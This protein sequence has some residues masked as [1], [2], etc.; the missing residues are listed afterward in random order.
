MAFKMLTSGA[1]TLKA[2]PRLAAAAPA[3]PTPRAG[4]ISTT[5][6][7]R[8]EKSLASTEL[9]M[10]SSSQWAQRS[11]VFPQSDR[12]LAQS[13]FFRTSASLGVS[14]SRS[15]PCSSAAR[16]AESPAIS[17]ST[18]GRSDFSRRHV[19]RAPSGMVSSVRSLSRRASSRPA[20][21]TAGM[22][23]RS[24][25]GEGRLD[26]TS[27]VARRDRLSTSR[28]CRCTA[29]R[30]PTICARSPLPC[31]LTAS[32]LNVS[33]RTPSPTARVAGAPLVGGDAAAASQGCSSPMR[34]DAAGARASAA[35][36]RR[37]WAR[38]CVR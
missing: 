18:H 35:Q 10:S 20:R 25:C 12:Q 37:A 7:R 2:S 17:A 23:S 3:S 34:P 11:P 22:T 13:P 14:G 27:S 28:A 29:V 19:E 9:Y 24:Q 8:Y 5:R 16:A 6:A 4:A 21:W 31:S 36:P 26:A 33:R 15:S 32:A 1:S 30:S 38:L